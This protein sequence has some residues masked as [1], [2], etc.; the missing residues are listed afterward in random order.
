[1]VMDEGGQRRDHRQKIETGF[2]Q[3]EGREETR[4]SI[5]VGGIETSLM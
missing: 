1:M 2:P 3:E 4:V 5:A